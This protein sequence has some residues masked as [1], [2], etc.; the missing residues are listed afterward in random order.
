MH[1]IGKNKTIIKSRGIHKLNRHKV[2]FCE[3]CKNPIPEISRTDKI[4]CNR[5]CKQSAYRQRPDVKENI[6]ERNRKYVEKHREELRKYHRNYMRKYRERQDVK[7]KEKKYSKKYESR[8]ETKEERAIYRVAHKIEKRIYDSEYHKKNREKL[9]KQ[10]KEY[11]K[12]PRGRFSRFLRKQR[13]RGRVPVEITFEQMKE[14]KKRD[15]N[16]CQYCGKKTIN[17]IDYTGGDKL[18]YD[19]LDPYGGTIINNLVISCKSCNT[20]KTDKDVF[21]FFLLKGEPI[22]KKILKLLESQ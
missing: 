18:V 6:K 20:V 8:P 19:H 2:K 10:K 3:W 5:K 9:N 13:R 22:P 14:I 1:K 12:T 15:K 21:E 17:K 4:Y 7:K 16:I 11:D